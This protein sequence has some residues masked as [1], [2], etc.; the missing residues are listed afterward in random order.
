MKVSSAYR[1]QVQFFLDS[2]DIKEVRRFTAFGLVDGVTTNPSLISKLGVDCFEK[3][4]LVMQLVEGPVSMQI[5]ETNYASALAQAEFLSKLGDNVV[6]KVPFSEN[7]YEIASA[8]VAHNIPVN[9]TSV[10]NVGQAIPFFRLG[11]DY[12]SVICG[13]RKEY[14][15]GERDLL[16][17]FV[18]ARARVQSETKLIGA[19]IRNIEDLCDS[20][21]AGADILTI[22]PSTWDAMF[23]DPRTLVTSQRFA[24]DW[25]RI[26]KRERVLFTANS[27]GNSQ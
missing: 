14:S 17:P 1:N 11:I 24:N 10:F 9:L 4:R 26:P 25:N 22:P 3:V 27:K 5:T 23:A 13:V 21:L 2:A 16:D 20:L 8:L 18:R 12:V 6:V 7:A 15:P 19:S